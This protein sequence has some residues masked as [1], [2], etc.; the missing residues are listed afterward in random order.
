MKSLGH[1][2]NK[3]ETVAEKLGLAAASYE[4]LSAIP[5]VVDY[6][7]GSNARV[8]WAGVARHEAKLQETLLRYLT[9]RKEISI[10][11]ERSW[12]PAVR[13]PTV[14][15]TVAGWNS[16]ELVETVEKE[17]DAGFRWGA[18]YSER[19]VK[20]ILQLGPEGVVRVSMVH[21]NTGEFEPVPYLHVNSHPEL[22]CCE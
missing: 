1:Y 8:H 3:H 11:G 7:N 6:L 16:Q 9:S 21:Y 13:V 18:F 19:L 10:W 4:L 20:E 22:T 2:F 17:C 12:D 15:F 14:S 5:A